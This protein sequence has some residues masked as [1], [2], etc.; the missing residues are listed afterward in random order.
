MFHRP[1]RGSA[2][3]NAG[4]CRAPKCV[5]FGLGDILQEDFI[6]FLFAYS[7]QEKEEALKA[8]PERQNKNKTK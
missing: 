8:S 2:P 4:L 1:A 7:T 3:E 6:I 5:K